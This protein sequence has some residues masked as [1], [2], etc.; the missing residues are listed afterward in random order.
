MSSLPRRPRARQAAVARQEAPRAQAL[1]LAVQLTP[2]QRHLMVQAG[3]P[4]WLQLPRPYRPAL[5]R[6]L[7]AARALASPE[8]GVLELVP[9]QADAYQLTPL[10]ELVA[11]IWLT[12]ALCDAE[13]LP[14]R[15]GHPSPTR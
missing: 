5:G 2:M 15:F 9:A 6:P 1:R 14:A 13:P 11:G 3:L 7:S 8:L 12:A 4:R 10:G